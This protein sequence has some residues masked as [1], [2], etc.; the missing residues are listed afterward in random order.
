MSTA[1]QDTR[2]IEWNESATPRSGVVERLRRGDRAGVIMLAVLAG[3]FLALFFRW[4]DKQQ[5][6]SR[7]AFE[8]WGHAFVVPVISGYY[9]WRRRHRLMVTPTCIYWPGLAV[10]LLGA[11]CYVYFISGYSN[12]MFQGFSLI[13]TLAG[14]VLLL[15]GPHMLR[16]M[17][18]PIGFL[19]FAITI[20]E[21]VMTGLTW[22]LKLLASRGAE[23]SLTTL[24]MDVTATGN[25]LEIAWQGRIIPLDVAEACSGMRM[26]VAFAALSAI[27][28]FFSCRHWWQ[29]CAIIMLA[30]PVALLMNI[31]RVD[32]LAAL[33]LWRPALAAGDAH[34]VIGTI[35]LVPAFLLFMGGAWVL[36]KLES[37]PAP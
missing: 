26:V 36:R 13:L 4:I 33:T 30:T 11:A 31:V 15:A 8:D 3:A 28:A 1:V 24:G 22:P 37:E 20:S 6:F 17:A 16:M 2:L 32:V 23:L 21:Q 27:V 9:L 19:G 7:S 25:K 12:H 14:V 35:L 29:R 5:Q 10:M 18:F 34:M